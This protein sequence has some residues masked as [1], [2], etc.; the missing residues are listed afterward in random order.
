MNRISFTNEIVLFNGI[1]YVVTGVALCNY[2][3]I[4]RITFGSLTEIDDPDNVEK[5]NHLSGDE[6]FLKAVRTKI[7]Y[8][9]PN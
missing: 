1:E 7:K 2:R 3:F 9:L 6:S 8:L 4:V 5:W